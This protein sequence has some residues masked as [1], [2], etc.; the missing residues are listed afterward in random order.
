VDLSLAIYRKR[1]PSDGGF[2]RFES[3]MILTEE[4]EP[5]TITLMSDP[6]DLSLIRKRYN[7]DPTLTVYK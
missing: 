7:P 5:E 6:E 2:R 4:E 3:R 1:G